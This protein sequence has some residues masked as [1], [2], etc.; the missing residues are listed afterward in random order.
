MIGC[1]YLAGFFGSSPAQSYRL[2][3]ALRESTLPR[4]APEPWMFTRALLGRGPYGS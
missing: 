2:P 1:G 3:V 4:I